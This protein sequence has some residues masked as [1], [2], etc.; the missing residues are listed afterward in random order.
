[1]YQILN[2]N[3]DA[4]SQLLKIEVIDHIRGRAWHVDRVERGYVN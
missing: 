3:Y 4:K 1:M 2:I